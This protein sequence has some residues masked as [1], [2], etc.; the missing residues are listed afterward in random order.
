MNHF[1]QLSQFGEEWFDYQ[2]LY[3]RM[4]DYFPTESTFVEV[5]S[6]KGRSAA[7]MCVEIV[8]SGKDI[9]F[10]CVDSWNDWWNEQENC[11]VKNLYSTFLKNLEPVAPYF[12]P[13]KLNSLDAAIK[14]KDESIDF[15]FLD[16]GHDYE[17]VKSDILAWYPKI[18]QGGI[19]AGHDY[20]PNHPT[21]D[22]YDAVNELFPNSHEYLENQYCFL[23]KKQ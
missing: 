22:V 2:N 17:S 23:K 20:F 9:E 19:L 8:N 13:L 14:F 3:K 12:K 10:Y 15:V 16:A 6:W 4:V 21:D 5:G 11:G 7:Y 1:Y 18:K